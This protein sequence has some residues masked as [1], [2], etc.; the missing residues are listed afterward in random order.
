MTLTWVYA[1]SH[2]FLVPNF[3][4]E[5]SGYITM[6]QL[7]TPAIFLISIC[8]EYLFPRAVLGPIVLVLIP[9]GYG[10]LDRSVTHTG[11]EHKSGKTDRTAILWRI[12]SILPWIL[13]IGLAVWAMSL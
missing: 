1:I 2:G 6:R 3:I 7:I 4:A 9:I 12:G 11:H 10:I 5:Q 8:A 13:T